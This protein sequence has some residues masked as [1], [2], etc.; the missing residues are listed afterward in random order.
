MVSFYV[1]LC[2]KDQRNGLVDYIVP[3]KE[4]VFLFVSLGAGRTIFEINGSTKQ[5]KCLI[6]QNAVRVHFTDG[7]FALMDCH[8]VHIIAL[9][10]FSLITDICFKMAF[11]S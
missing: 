11:F 2:T 10:A 7:F 9:A 3:H 1:F 5:L 4:Y 6:V 8:I